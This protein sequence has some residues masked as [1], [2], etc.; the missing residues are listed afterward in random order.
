MTWIGLV[1]SFSLVE[2]VVLVQLLGICPC[3]GAPRRTGTA[4]GIGIA[5]AVMMGLASLAAWAVRTLVL[6]PLGLEALEALAYAACVALV[7][8]LVEWA[9]GRAAPGLARASGFS[10]RGAAV[11]CAVLGTALLVSRRAVPLTA[12]GALAGPGFG[13][14]ES[15]VAGLAAGC[16][17]LVVMVL[18][19]AIRG[20]L[21]TE[22]VPAALRGLPI[23]LV[24]AGLL[25]L[26]FLAFDSALV[27]R[28]LP[29][30]RVAP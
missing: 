30:L 27:S 1:L 22:R 10:V 21:D 17:M 28:L 7:A 19:S 5:S 26:A 29:G 18:L 8:L 20:R 4:L 12:A 2:N 9:A 24:S 25:A 14:L 23:A 16:G 13:P 3:A 6:A 11:N 15:L